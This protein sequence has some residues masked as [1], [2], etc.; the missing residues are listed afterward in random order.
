MVGRENQCELGSMTHRETGENWQ[1]QGTED[2]ST[3]SRWGGQTE[4]G[5]GTFALQARRM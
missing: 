3:V 5:G 1:G 4:A 2:A